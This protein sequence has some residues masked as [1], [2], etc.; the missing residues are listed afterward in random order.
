MAQHI[1]HAIDEQFDWS[2]MSVTT[3]THK[4]NKD[5]IRSRLRTLKKEGAK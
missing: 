2:A 4:Q 5:D 1:I 3:N